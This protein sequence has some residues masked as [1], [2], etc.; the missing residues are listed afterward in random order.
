MEKISA[1]DYNLAIYFYVFQNH[2]NFHPRPNPNIPPRSSP[3]TSSTAVNISQ[4]ISTLNNTEDNNNGLDNSY[5]QPEIDDENNPAYETMTY[6]QPEVVSP[7][8][9]NAQP[10][11]RYIL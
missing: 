1:L 6:R 4:S 5:Q 3:N 9:S 10:G 11:K 7:V 2:F 8:N